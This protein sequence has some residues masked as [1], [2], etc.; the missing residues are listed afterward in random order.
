M[1]RERCG[2]VRDRAAACGVHTHALVRTAALG[3][4]ALG[5]ALTGHRGSRTRAMAQ[6]PAHAA[7][8]SWGM[9]RSAPQH[10]L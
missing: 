2:V 8:C 4:M 3:R 9:R 10:L 5:T 6:A 1:W 7:C